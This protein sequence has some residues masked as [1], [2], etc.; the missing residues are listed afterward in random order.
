MRSQHCN[1]GNVPWPSSVDP[2][3]AGL[4]DSFRKIHKDPLAEPGIT[5]SPTYLDDEGRPE[6]MD[7]INFIYHKSLRMLNSQTQVVGKPIPAGFWS[8]Q[9]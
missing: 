6:L 9:Y 4:L 8:K 7:C 1:V 3:K 2:I 5:W